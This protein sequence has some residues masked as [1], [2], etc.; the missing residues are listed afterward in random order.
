M[1][2]FRHEIQS[3]RATVMNPQVDPDWE[4]IDPSI[5]F[6]RWCE[7]LDRMANEPQIQVLLKRPALGFG[8]GEVHWVHS[9][10]E[11]RRLIDEWL[12]KHP[13]GS[14]VIV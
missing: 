10:A 6:A 7:E 5:D 3:D 12:A 11:A 1:S 2:V 13:S 14:A 8:R 4:L 9:R